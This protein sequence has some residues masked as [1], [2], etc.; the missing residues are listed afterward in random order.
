MALSKWFYNHNSMFHTGHYDVKRFAQELVLA[1]IF[2]AIVSLSVFAFTVV[3][4][5]WLPF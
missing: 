4:L 1:A 5:K 3:V 2:I